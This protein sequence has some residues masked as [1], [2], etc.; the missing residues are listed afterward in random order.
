MQAL[1]SRELGAVLPELGRE[2][3]AGAQAMLRETLALVKREVGS[4]SEIVAVGGA[5][6]DAK[7][8]IEGLTDRALQW[9]SAL[10]SA[11]AE[12]MVWR[13]WAGIAS[14]GFYAMGERERVRC[15]ELAV[16]AGEW[17]LLKRV[18]R[19]PQR[20]CDSGTVC[21]WELIGGEIAVDASGEGSYEQAWRALRTS[22]P[23]EDH[24]TTERALA[25]ISSF[26]IEEEDG[27]EVRFHP[28]SY[29]FFEPGLCAVAA[30]ARR[31]GF[32]AEALTEEQRRFLEAGLEEGE[33]PPLVPM[34]FAV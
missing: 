32:V 25:E 5:G 27:E 12:P 16:L 18:D 17:E 29:P 23:R 34:V 30:L 24:R 7:W 8:G 6:I 3:I 31:R 15:A 20:A 14:A 33:P 22:V 2:R 26:W 21:F 28:G 10:F 9:C 11:G 4:I 1:I 13:R 19:S